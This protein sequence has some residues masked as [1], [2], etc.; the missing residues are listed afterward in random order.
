MCWRPRLVHARRPFGKMALT[1]LILLKHPVNSALHK[2]DLLVPE[3]VHIY[4][5]CRPNL[6]SIIQNWRRPMTGW[7]HKPCLSQ[8]YCRAAPPTLVMKHQKLTT[9]N[10]EE[11]NLPYRGWLGPWEPRDAPAFPPSKRP[12]DGLKIDG[13]L[14][15][16][17]IL[18]GPPR[19]F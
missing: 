4:P 1:P 19:L 8:S 11:G 3:V 6:Y 17:V 7:W 5:A 13:G 18:V 16:G 14:A 2:G 15:N 9:D 10:E 12:M